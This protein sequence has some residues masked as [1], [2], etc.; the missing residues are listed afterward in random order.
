MPRAAMWTC[1]SRC[2][3]APDRPAGRGSN[4]VPSAATVQYRR[5][6]ATLPAQDRPQHY[7][8][9]T[10]ILVSSILITLIGMAL[11]AYLALSIA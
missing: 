4:R 9:G 8:G 1:S 5:L 2:S 10:L 6:I 3:D 11:T 7:S